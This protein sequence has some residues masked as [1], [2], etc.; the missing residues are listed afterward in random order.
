MKPFSHRFLYINTQMNSYTCL[1]GL[2]LT[3]VV[4]DPVLKYENKG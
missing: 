1:A 3:N 4:L 2:Q